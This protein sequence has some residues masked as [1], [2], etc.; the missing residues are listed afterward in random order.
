M[1]IKFSFHQQLVIGES[2]AVIEVT[3]EKSPE[4][5]GGNQFFIIR[6]IEKYRIVEEECTSDFEDDFTICPAYGEGVVIEAYDRNR[7]FYMS[8]PKTIEQKN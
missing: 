5:S 3:C 8:L 4:I 6:P 7:N 2:K 1:K